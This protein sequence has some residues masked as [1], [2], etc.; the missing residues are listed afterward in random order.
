MLD[1]PEIAVAQALIWTASAP[2]LSGSR[3]H[4]S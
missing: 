3:L 4:L 2:H 1:D